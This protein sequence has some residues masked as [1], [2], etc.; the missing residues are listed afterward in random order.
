MD[1]RS[2]RCADLWRTCP[3]AVL[4]VTVLLSAC[5]RIQLAYNNLDWLLPHYLASYMPLSDDQ[6]S[7]LETRVNHFLH[8]HCS[9]QVGTYAQ[10][11]REAN[12]RFQSGTLTRSELEQFN[13]RVEQAW[14]GIMHQASIRYC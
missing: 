1:N 2:Y 10:L 9:T 5:S 3:A 11:L 8:W 7:L 6:D 4:I 14:A 12:D 13:K